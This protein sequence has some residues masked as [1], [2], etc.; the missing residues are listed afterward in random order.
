MEEKLGSRIVHVR[1][2][3]HS[4]AAIERPDGTLVFAS[5][6]V[7]RG[8]EMGTWVG[9]V[10]YWFVRKADFAREL[11]EAGLQPVWQPAP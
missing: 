3:G 6:F 8:R 7:P 5:D 10:R 4:F 2:E 11:K 1:R 9:G